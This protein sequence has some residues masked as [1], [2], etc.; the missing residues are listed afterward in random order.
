MRGII[1][2]KNI[3]YKE[4][5]YLP[6]FFLSGPDH[7]ITKPVLRCLNHLETTIKSSKGLDLGSHYNTKPYSSIYWHGSEIEKN[8]NENSLKGHGDGIGTTSGKLVKSHKQKSKHSNLVKSQ[9]DDHGDHVTETVVVQDIKDR[10]GS[11]TDELSSLDEDDYDDLV[12]DQ[13]TVSPSMYRKRQ[14]FKKRSQQLNITHKTAE[15]DD[16]L[17]PEDENLSEIVTPVRSESRSE[18]DPKV[19]INTDDDLEYSEEYEHP[20]VVRVSVNPQNKYLDNFSKEVN[21]YKKK[22]KESKK[23]QKKAF[24]SNLRPQSA[25][26]SQIEK[27][28]QNYRIARNYHVTSNQITQRAS[29]AP[30]RRYQSH[31]RP[32]SASE[33]MHSKHCYRPGPHTIDIHNA[34]S[35][36]GPNSNIKSLIKEPISRQLKHDKEPHIHQ[37]AW[38]H[39]PGR[40]P[41]VDQAYPPKRSQERVPSGGGVRSASRGRT[42]T[43]SVRGR[44]Q[45]RS[46]VW[47]GRSQDVGS[48]QRGW[49]H[50]A[51]MHMLQGWPPYRQFMYY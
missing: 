5:I 3:K 44:G 22:V 8:E 33:G 11:Y 7:H 13:R 45:Q 10:H 38:Y 14:A 28:F 35:V 34:Y 15:P 16:G 18:N 19:V 17:C 47:R 12:F 31:D 37:S 43:S 29:S 41:T 20:H 42:Y 9:G 39:V 2:S 49:R 4:K 40:Y 6:R 26:A 27:P 46:Q 36:S 24:V 25:P 51:G 50:Q 32:L 21:F 23:A 30:I 1:C 48:L